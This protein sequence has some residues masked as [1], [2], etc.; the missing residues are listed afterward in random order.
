MTIKAIR[1]AGLCIMMKLL[2]SEM[3]AYQNYVSREFYYIMTDLITFY[4]WRHRDMLRMWNDPQ[5][6]K[7]NIQA[8]SGEMPDVI[9][10]WGADGFIN[11]RAK[12]VY[13]LDC[14]K[15]IFSDDL[16]W[17][18]EA[19]RLRKH[20]SFWLCDTI[21]SAYEYAFKSF[22]PQIYETRCV[23]WVPHSASPDFML[24]FNEQ[25]E[26]TIFL[27]GAINHHYP[28]RE[29]MK[30]LYKRSAYPIIYHEHPGYHCRYD[31][32]KTDGVGRAYAKRINAC[33]VGFTDCLTHKY[34]VAKY[35]EIPATGAL[36]LAD[37]AVSEN[38]R[39]LGFI[40]NV[41][42][43]SVSSASL[44]DRLKYVLDESNHQEID[45]IRKRGQRL[46]VE[47]HKTRDRAQL[48]DEVCERL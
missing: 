44:E 10:F 36:L 26:N 32:E 39:T 29:Q 13:N 37:E 6:L 28:L 4:G 41:H 9:L 7:E 40:E 46:I 48:I 8:T 12:E 27:S 1:L 18:N 16:H 15:C 19:A 2:I 45:G 11:K 33:R 42:Y 20:I 30:S 23:V 17:H 22:Y 47:K 25:A 3:G 21:F 43:M 5:P 31:Y 24:A 14:H 38:F 35:F 34:I